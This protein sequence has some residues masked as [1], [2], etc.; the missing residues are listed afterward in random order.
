LPK[1][2]LDMR[3]RPLPLTILTAELL[4][5]AALILFLWLDEIWDIPHYLFGVP[6]T[7]T[8]IQ[9]SIIETFMALALAVLVMSVTV[10]SALGLARATAEKDKLFSVIA[11]DLRSPF[12]SLLGN[13][14]LLAENGDSLSDQELRAVAGSIHRSATGLFQLLQDLLVWGQVQLGT[15]KCDPKPVLVREA[16][17]P[18]LAMLSDT[19][20]KKKIDVYTTIDGR[21][22]VYADR[23]MFSS[24]LQNLLSNAIKFT[25]AGGRVDI[26]ARSSNGETEVIVA[27][28]GVGMSPAQMGELFQLGT[29]TSRPGTEGEMG[30]GL[31]L[32]ICQDLVRRNGGRLTVESTEGQGSSFTVSLPSG[33]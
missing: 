5:F 19:A 31:G 17:M 8:N 32:V 12:T 1:R 25:P 14:A 2:E 10:R 24:V 16:L 15:I 21:A 11:H 28:T 20:A 3:S 18:I 29:C 33:A 4:G 6:P 13:S 27:D 26:T 9:E 22:T 30:T 23:T 7:P